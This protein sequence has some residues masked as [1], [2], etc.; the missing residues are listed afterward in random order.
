MTTRTTVL[1]TA[2][3]ALSSLALFVALGGD[4]YAARL[5]G[6]AQIKRDAIASKH[7]RA[8]AVTSADVRDGTIAARDLA[9][10]LLDVVGA[11]G[12][13]GETGPQGLAGPAG[14]AGPQG[15]T[16][17]QGPA[18]PIGPS[19]AYAASRADG[20][21][22][23]VE[24]PAFSTIRLLTVPAGSYVVNAKLRLTD[25]GDRAVR[26]QLGIVNDTGGYVVIVDEA[27]ADMPADVNATSQ[28]FQHV[29]TAAAGRTYGLRCRRS[30]TGSGGVGVNDAKLTAIRVGAVVAG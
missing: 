30:D 14:P 6:G 4:S 27:V 17:P 28:A 23:I 18:G 19:T 15:E 3:V 9:P 12:P 7:L 24:T 22:S 1:N 13:G 11:P 16:G 2:A 29:D 10:A 20:P 8:G 25:D 21:A 5:I 26:C